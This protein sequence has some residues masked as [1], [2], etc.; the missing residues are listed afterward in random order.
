M[1]S[2]NNAAEAHS[3]EQPQKWSVLKWIE[4]SFLA[5][6][7]IYT[8]IIF[9]P[10]IFNN[11]S[12]AIEHH[13]SQAQLTLNTVFIA[14]NLFLSLSTLVFLATALLFNRRL[15]HPWRKLPA[16]IF[17]TAY[18]L[19]C[20][21]DSLAHLVSSTSLPLLADVAMQLA[22]GP[23]AILNDLARIFVTLMAIWAIINFVRFLLPKR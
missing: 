22:P 23:M 14:S 5:V 1:T 18:C 8:F 9:I 4:S 6:S 19:G 10:G 17:V 2:P 16:L 20:A 21:Y 7:L 3:A 11:I 13:P 15:V 12:M